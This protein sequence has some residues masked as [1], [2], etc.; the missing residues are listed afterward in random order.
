MTRLDRSSL[1]AAG[2]GLVALVGIGLL[3]LVVG[4]P[5]ASTTGPGGMM[6]GGMMG[7]GMMGGGMMGGSGFFLF[8][9]TLFAFAALLAFGYVGVRAVASG[10]EED[11]VDD[12]VDGEAELDPITRLQRRYTEGEL[13]EAEFERALERELE[14]KEGDGDGEFDDEFGDAERSASLRQR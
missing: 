8:P 4:F 13:T 7:S 5:T 12:G 6:G 1:V 2:I 9:L 14:G 3:A 10:G 11:Q